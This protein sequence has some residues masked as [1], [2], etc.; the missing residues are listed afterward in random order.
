MK[1]IPKELQAVIDADIPVNA[2]RRTFHHGCS[3]GKDAAL[4]VKRLREGYVFNCFRCDFKGFIGGRKLP[5]GQILS[6]VKGLSVKPHA[7]IDNIVLPE[8]FEWMATPP[9]MNDIPIEAYTWLWNSGVTERQMDDYEFC[10]SDSYRR[11]II[12]IKDDEDKLQGFLGRDVFYDK[13]TKHGDKY[14]LRKERGLNR[15]Y[16]TCHVLDSM[17]VVIVEDPL[18]AIRVH[19][20]T[21]YETVALLNTH[22]GTDLLRE[23]MNYKMVVWLDR[24]QLSNMVGIVARAQSYG[25]KCS[26]ISTPKDPKAYNDVAI[27]AMF[28]ERRTE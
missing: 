3:E 5:T 6:M 25:I 7:E 18:S 16:F 28:P 24:G 17:T 19:D 21:G 10:W 14:I 27:Q 1:S 2:S 9:D 15:I 12:P 13:E 4:S 8:D 26:H 11:V 22:V 20:A 23:Y